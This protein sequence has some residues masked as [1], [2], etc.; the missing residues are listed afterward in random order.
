MLALLGFGFYIFRFLVRKDYEQQGQLS[1]LTSW[2][3]VVFFATHGMASYTFLPAK[4][5]GM[6][7]LPENNLQ[8]WFGFGLAG[9]GLVL[10]LWAMSGLGFEK[11][12]GQD[13]EGLNRSGFYKYIRNPQ[14][15]FYTILLFGYSSLWPSWYSLGWLLVYAQ[16]AHWMVR[17]EEE[18]LTHLFGNAYTL[19]CQEVGRYL[20]KLWR[21]N[22]DK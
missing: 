1:N 14:I 11:S 13:V 12:V 17:A 10:T 19:Y 9:L 16:A 20:P 22:H 5:P 4:F 7:P 2:L 6:P 21:G 8:V 3:E 15:V 18:H